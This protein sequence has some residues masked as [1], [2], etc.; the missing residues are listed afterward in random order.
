MKAILNTDNGTPYLGVE[1]DDKMLKFVLLQYTENWS[2]QLD[3][4]IIPK[5]IEFL[6]NESKN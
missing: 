4:R 1:I 3:K 2:L 5:L 6:K